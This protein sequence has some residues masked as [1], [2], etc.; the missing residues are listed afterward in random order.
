MLQTS[1][2][3]YSSAATKHNQKTRN[4]KEKSFSSEK[5]IVR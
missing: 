2:K 5:L 4:S 1:L 3:N